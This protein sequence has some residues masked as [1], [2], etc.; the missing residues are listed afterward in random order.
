MTYLQLKSITTALLTGD[1]KLPTD[2]DV[3][4]GMVSYA[5]TTVAMK[6]DS[7]HLMTLSTDGDILRLGSGDYVIRRPAVPV[8]DTDVTDIDE[9][10][11]YAVARYLAGMVSKEKGAIH[12]A[13]AE[14]IILDYNAKTYEIIDQMQQ[15]AYL[16]DLKDQISILNDPVFSL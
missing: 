8:L 11:N 14:R 9:E 15:E 1:N 6:A 7:L 13:A 4:H 5:L 12:N 10:L 2:A 3:L 16:A